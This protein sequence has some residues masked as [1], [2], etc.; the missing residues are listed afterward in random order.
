MINQLLD[1]LITIVVF[2]GCL[3]AFFGTFHIVGKV[4]MW[5]ENKLN[6]NK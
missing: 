3:V 5:A 4:G 1:M 2:F 6:K